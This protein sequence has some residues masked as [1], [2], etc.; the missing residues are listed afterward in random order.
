MPEARRPPGI[1]RTRSLAWSLW[2]LFVTHMF[3]I[4][5]A[6]FA[7][8]GREHEAVGPGIPL[9]VMVTIGTLVASRWPANPIGWSLIALPLLV[10]VSFGVSLYVPGAV[11]ARPGIA[12]AYAFTLAIWLFVGRLLAGRF[13]ALDRAAVGAIGRVPFSALFGLLL[14]AATLWLLCGLVAGVATQVPGVRAAVA[15]LA[16]STTFPALITDAAGRIIDSPVEAGSVAAI[17]LAYA[18]SA[19]NLGLGVFVMRLHGSEWV[20]RALALGLVGTAAVFNLQAHAAL[21]VAPLFDYVHSAFHAAAGV[22]YVVALLLFPDGRFAVHWP[23]RR[24]LAWPARVLYTLL[25]F[26]ALLLFESF[27]GD[28]AGFVVLFGVLIPLAGLTSQAL[29]YRQAAT[30]RQR[31]Q[32]RTLIWV[33]ALAFAAALVVGLLALLIGTAA[34]L[35]P[36][37]RRQLDELTFFAFP[38][39]FAIIP[40]ALVLVMVRYQLWDIDK[41][42][43]RALVYSLATAVLGLTYGATVVLLSA[44]LGPLTQGSELAVV[45]STLVTAALF[46]PARERIQTAI[47]RRFFRQRYSAARAV[48]VLAARLRSEVDLDAVRADLVG[49]VYETLRPMHASVW[50]RPP[51]TASPTTRPSRSRAR[52]SGSVL[53]GP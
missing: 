13:P 32:S 22:S 53:S 38:A 42:L 23:R 47:D 46:R 12:L 10:A 14:A 51:G 19:L 7:T 43:N 49:V 24:W 17:A 3:F 6:L 35:T 9:L 36:A 50:L 26:A 41:F 4:S 45:G 2:A 18:I 52:G 20:A 16:A 37:T 28:P 1:P 33:L 48:D 25:P 21:V 40:V 44:L 27:H 31:Q 5:S 29:R 34:E 11:G 30:P 15:E 8:P 39:L